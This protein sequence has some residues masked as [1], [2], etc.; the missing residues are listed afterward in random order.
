MDQCSQDPKEG[1]EL[2]GSKPPIASLRLPTNHGAV[3]AYLLPSPCLVA[4]ELSDS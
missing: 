2:Q 1:A 4:A 3:V